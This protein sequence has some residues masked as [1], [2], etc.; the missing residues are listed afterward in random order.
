MRGSRLAFVAALVALALGCGGQR[1]DADAGADAGTPR[2]ARVS[3]DAFAP[4]AARYDAWAPLDVGVGCRATR[5]RL[6]EEI[7]RITSCTRDEECGLQLDPRC[8]CSIDRVARLDA[9]RTRFDE[10]AAQY[11]LD[12]SGTRF[13]V[14]DRPCEYCHDVVPPGVAC[15]EGTCTQTI[16]DPVCFFDGAAMHVDDTLPDAYDCNGC[17]CEADGFA[18]CTALICGDT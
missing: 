10:L 15:I 2:D 14:L 17:S 1:I 4:D 16:A 5:Y 7:A 13:N 3:R 8:G 18:H 9:D 12:C 11:R 6:R